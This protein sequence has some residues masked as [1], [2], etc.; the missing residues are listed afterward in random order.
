MAPRERVS[1]G[2]FGCMVGWQSAQEEL[3]LSSHISLRALWLADYKITQIGLS[4]KF[5]WLP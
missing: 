1:G 5:Y 3:T 4:K 2:E